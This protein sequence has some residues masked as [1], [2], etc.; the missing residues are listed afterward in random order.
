MA[1]ETS[2]EE[3]TEIVVSEYRRAGAPAMGEGV[4]VTRADDHSA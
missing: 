2:V 3:L 1:S 4:A